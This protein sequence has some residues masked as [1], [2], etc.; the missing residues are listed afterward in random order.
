[1]DL[2]ALKEIGMQVTK[3][4]SSKMGEFVKDFGENFLN[5]YVKNGKWKDASKKFFKHEFDDYLISNSH[6]EQEEVSLHNIHPL[7][8]ELL[9][10]DKFLY[11]IKTYPIPNATGLAALRKKGRDAYYIY[12]AFV[13][14]DNLI[15]QENNHYLIFI[16]DGLSIDLENL[17]GANELIVLQ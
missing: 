15:E 3:N 9:S 1:M 6:K 8:F 13:I 14:N 12:T 7:K 16:A 5:E 4:I 17:F 2:N 10:K 11:A